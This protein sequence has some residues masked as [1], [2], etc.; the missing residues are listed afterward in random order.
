MKN[1][2]IRFQI[3]SILVLFLILIS[4]T[5]G[6]ALNGIT[7][8]YQLLGQHGSQTDAAQVLAQLETVKEHILAWGGTAVLLSIVSGV[9]I[10]TNITSFL[11][12]QKKSDDFFLD[13][14][15]LTTD[16][17]KITN[18][19]HSLQ[20]DMTVL[21]KGSNTILDYLKQ[22]KQIVLSTTD[23]FKQHI[24]PN[25]LA[26][27]FDQLTHSLERIEK[28]VTQGQE[29][30]V[31][32]RKNVEKVNEL[33]A[34]IQEVTKKI[35][36][37]ANHTG[38]L[39][40]NAEI[41]AAKA[42]EQ[43]KG[44]AVVAEEM[45]TIAVNIKKLTEKIENFAR[46][47]G[48]AVELTK[49]AIEETGGFLQKVVEHTKNSVKIVEK[50]QEKTMGDADSSKNLQDVL[51]D[52]QQKCTRSVTKLDEINLAAGMQANIFQNLLKFTNSLE[53][54]IN[55]LQSGHETKSNQK[56][57]AVVLPKETDTM[58]EGSHREATAEGV[59]PSPE[60]VEEK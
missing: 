22:V 14:T 17:K 4:A 54:T 57:P 34:L 27:T 25:E 24:E 1:G 58:K 53:I 52:L 26:R 32:D 8:I 13:T 51:F 30:N 60:D 29:S 46:E 59:D 43:G 23:G 33:A 31:D 40:L 18:T 45:A 20:K 19:T 41:E 38:T 49:H 48:T 50:L 3:G 42:G 39:A 2:S 21:S 11:Q 44:F 37:M 15:P 56:M 10:M 47:A 16:L 9:W 28:E 36:D 6:I 12:S 35:K 55:N 7:E 5:L